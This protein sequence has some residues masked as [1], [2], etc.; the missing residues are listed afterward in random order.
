[1]QASGQTSCFKSLLLAALPALLEATAVGLCLGLWLKLNVFMAIAGGLILAPVCPALL[2][3]TMNSWQQCGLG[4]STG[5][6]TLE[7]E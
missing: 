7:T 1:M 2:H 3:A 6:C 4:I 5:V